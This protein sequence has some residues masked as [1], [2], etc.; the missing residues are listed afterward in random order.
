MPRGGPCPW[1]GWAF[2]GVRERRQHGSVVNWTATVPLE[3]CQWHLCQENIYKEEA[4]FWVVLPQALVL[5]PSTASTGLSPR[6]GQGLPSMV[7]PA[8]RSAQ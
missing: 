4:G 7:G 1:E 8:R 3:G 5:F 2:P 6:G